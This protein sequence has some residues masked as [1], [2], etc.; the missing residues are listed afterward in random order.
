MSS[1]LADALLQLQLNHVFFTIFSSS[2]MM[3]SLKL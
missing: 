2:Q 3:Y 1:I